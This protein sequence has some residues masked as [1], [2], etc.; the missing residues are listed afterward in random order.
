VTISTESLDMWKSLGTDLGFTP[1][2]YVC[3]CGAGAT[4]NLL[5]LQTNPWQDA[6]AARTWDGAPAMPEGE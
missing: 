2:T 6:R 1:A 4:P 5:K 3:G